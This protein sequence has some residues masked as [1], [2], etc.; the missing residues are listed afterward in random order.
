MARRLMI[1]TILLALVASACGGDDDTVDA[2]DP[3][4]DTEQ[5]AVTTTTVAETVS[6][7]TSTTTTPAA[8][9]AVEGP[10]VGGDGPVVPQPATALP[11]GYVEEEFFIGGDATRYGLIGEQT[12]DGMWSAQAAESAAYRTRVLV[13]RPAAAD[14]SGTVLLEWLNVTATEASPDWGYLSEEIGRAGHVYVAASIQSLGV[15]GGNSLLQIET[16]TEVG[17]ES[18]EADTSGLVNIDPERY[19]SLVHPGDAY[20][21][22]MYTQIGQAFVDRSGGL[23]G[24]LEP[25]QVIALGESQSAGFLTT[26]INAI[27]PLTPTFDAFLVHSRGAGGAPIGGD[28]G[29]DD[30]G[31]FVN[32]GHQIRT[33][34]AEPVFMVQA[35]TDLTVL[36]YQLARQPDT[37]TIRTWEMAGTAHA[38]AHVVRSVIGGGRDSSLGFFL[39]CT[40]PINA[41][42]HHEIVAAALA[43]LVSWSAGGDAPPAGDRLE[44]TD[45]DPAEIARDDLGRALG[46]VRNPLVDVP[47]AVYTGDPWTEVS[48]DDPD[49]FDVCA[50][51]GQTFALAGSVLV[52][53]HGDA[54]SYVAAFGDAATAAVEAGFLLPADAEEL[55]AEAETNRALFPGS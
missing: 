39:G 27:H 30:G 14:F 52:D 18:T 45:D 42:P 29:G 17:E 12:A 43:H 38:D 41:G 9:A 32:D 10:I 2:P 33:D 16:T 40:Q 8:P 13:R 51:F 53:L 15:V 23:L 24:D 3:V 46:G 50:L 20:A 25:D 7:T 31:S 22:D 48:A 47:I 49:S 6:E 28:F 34:L 37:D 44:L 5:E 35:E 11:E 4:G 21:Y 36:G 54:D 1:V 26:Y 55:R 19:G